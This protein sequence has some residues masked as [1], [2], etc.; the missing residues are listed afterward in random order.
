MKHVYRYRTCCALGT[1][2]T[3]LALGAV[4]P[5]AAQVGQEQAAVAETLSQDPQEIVV[6]GSLIRGTPE[7]AALPVDLISGEE[8]ARQ[9]SPSLVELIKA[10]PTSN[11]VLG[12]A[13]QFDSRSQGAEG[14]ANINLRGLGP[15]RT[16][17]LLNSRRLVRTGNGVPS[18]D[19][20]LL[21]LAAIGRVEILKD[22]G[23]ATYGSDAVAGVVNFFTRKDQEGFIFSGDYKYVEGSKGDYNISAS[24]GHD[25]GNGFRVLLAAGFQH[26][27]ELFTTD[28]DFALKP[29]TE[30]PEGGWTSGGQPSV[31][32]P[33]SAA[34]G[35]LSG[36]FLIDRGCEAL[37]GFITGTTNAAGVFTPNRC[38]TQFTPF[39][40]LTETENRLQFY[41]ETEIDVTPRDR[42]EIT[43]LYGY[44]HVPHYRTSP[45]YLLTQAPSRASLPASF[46]GTQLAGFFVP[47]ENPGYQSYLAANPG[48]IPTTVPVAPGLNVPVAGVTFPLLLFR[49]YLSGGNPLFQDTPDD[50]GSAN[51]ERVSNSM[52]FTATLTHEF[53]RSLSLDLGLT[54][55]NYERYIDSFDSFGDRVQLALRGFGGN[56]CNPALNTPGQNGCF[57]LNPFSNSVPGNPAL[58]LPNPGFTP[59]VANSAELT[60]FFF[61]RAASQIDT[62]L[63][64]AEGVL[65]GDLG[66]RLP[67]GEVK[68]ALG[69]QFRANDYDAKY[70]PNNNIDINPCR[71]TPVTGNTGPCL[72]NSAAPG[73]PPGPRTG[74][75]AF[76]G[77]NDD[78]VFSSEAYA[79]FGELQLPIFD[80]LNASL[81]ARYEQYQGSVG[82]TFDPQLRL[83]WQALEWLA[84]RAGV[85]TTFRAP[86]DNQLSAG[87]VTSL[88]VIGGAFRPVDVF[89]NPALEPE[90][91]TNYSAGVI[92]DRGG[93]N[94]TI[95]YFRYDLDGAIV[96]EPTAGL[97]NALFPNGTS[98][99][100]PNNCADPA[101]A[102]L[103]NRFTFNNGGGVPGAGTCALT[104]VSR[105]RTGQVN[106][107]DIKTSGIDI[108]T[109]WR[110][111]DVLGGRLSIG[112]NA[113][114]VI[115]Y[116]V[117]DQT[118]EG[119][120]VSPAFDG[121]G[122]L[123]FQ[124]SIYPVPEWKGQAYV[125]FG[126]GIFDT[127]LTVTYI[128]SYVDQRT[129]PFAP[130]PELAGL[131]TIAD[132]KVIDEFI[133]ADLNLRLQL[134]WESTLTFT[135]LNITDEDP[136]FARL[137]YNYDPF[138]GNPLGRQF[139]IGL[140][141]RF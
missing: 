141:K 11:G 9:G 16:L 61:V 85:G 48:A 90:S 17:V 75:L 105:I 118:V 37:G 83:R 34:G 4:S 26:R 56:A 135:V 54:Y 101:F 96:V 32:L 30:N 59:A 84:F 55:H 107:V 116:K 129:A 77:T 127:R 131:P 52:R 24:Y 58:D 115:D 47:R 33:V 7:N 45:S 110:F 62:E 81:A 88:Q 38:Q 134:P 63:F 86:P 108:Q 51:G 66:I 104:N 43:A 3:V 121:V 124:T 114:Y 93:F 113:T 109:N 27:S 100:L 53:S 120:V 44:S 23:A 74:A 28:R 18:V 106:G 123:N 136:S 92:V 12:D 40:A 138:T 112:G 60:S 2:A 8:L 14:I 132:G 79:V 98:T 19:I 10:L 111:E 122:K 70:S 119:I 68:F 97:V 25:T 130:R 69:G 41:V 20:N 65:S 72:P 35:A 73:S 31:F 139:K 57:Y 71:E 1:L 140:T 64:V 133:T 99:S 82:H 36:S 29:Y 21:P 13:N 94:L 117:S 49:P 95:D 102:G 15:T 91:A 39:D 42:L 87:S 46:T 6:T 80:T 103:R 126:R 67:G 50:R 76:L 128:D 22:G 125:E 89:G 5:A 78:D 137:E